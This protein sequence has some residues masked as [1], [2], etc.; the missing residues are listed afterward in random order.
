[1]DQT[2][3]FIAKNVGN[4]SSLI[5]DYTYPEVLAGTFERKEAKEWLEITKKSDEP[6]LFGISRDMIETFLTDRGFSSV[7][8]VSSE[9]FNRVYFTGV[10]QGRE[11]TP[12]LSIAHAQ[13]K[14]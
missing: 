9:Y 7:V 12:V 5:F 1:V 10:H 13:V 4:G 8:S 11:S 6:L 14:F 2:L 3:S